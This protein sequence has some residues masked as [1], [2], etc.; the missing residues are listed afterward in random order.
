LKKKLSTTS[1]LSPGV[2]SVEIRFTAK[3]ANGIVSIKSKSSSKTGA[4]IEIKSCTYETD[5]KGHIKLIAEVVKGASFVKAAN[6]VVTTTSAATKIIEPH[7]LEDQNDG[8]YTKYFVPKQ[9]DSFQMECKAS[10]TEGKTFFVAPKTAGSRKKRSVSNEELSGEFLREVTGPGIKV[11]KVPSNYPPAK[12]FDLVTLLD[13]DDKIKIEFKATGA[14]LDEGTAT[15]YEIKY[16]KNVSLLYEDW[17]SI[18]TSD[19]AT[20]SL[21]P[22]PASQKMEFSV[23]R[24]IFDDGTVYFVA[25]KA[26]DDKGLSSEISNVAR[27]YNKKLPEILEVKVFVENVEYG[28][29]VDSGAKPGSKMGQICFIQ[30]LAFVMLVLNF[31]N[32]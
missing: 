10:G 14:D 2:Y 23:K 31:L 24:D 25:L 29:E 22:K 13:G 27:F 1:S 4:P 21:E 30:S 19:V 8:S 7:V 5:N 6:V 18:K 16:T 17:D 12:V 15:K 3:V 28:P 26:I 11:E 9:A 20:G 32:Y